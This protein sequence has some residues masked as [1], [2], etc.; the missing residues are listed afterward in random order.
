MQIPKEEKVD[1]ENKCKRDRFPIK[2]LSQFEIDK[3]YFLS[4][5]NNI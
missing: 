3:L 4:Y 5:L 1:G 2:F